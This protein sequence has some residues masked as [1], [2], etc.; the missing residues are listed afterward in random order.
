MTGVILGWVILSFALIRMIISLVN[1]LSPVFLPRTFHH[2]ERFVSVL[3]PA[4]N[5][6]QNLPKLLSTLMTQDHSNMEVLVYDDHSEDGTG[7]VVRKFSEKDNRIQLIHG[8]ELPHGWLGKNFACHQLATHAR[9]AYL[10]FLDADVHV[11]SSLVNRCVQYVHAHQLALLSFFPRQEIRS[12]GEWVT[13]PLMNWILLTLL[14]LV[15]VRKSPRPSLAAANGQLMMFQTDIYHKHQWHELV[16]DDL[17]E[18]IV[19]SREMKEKGYKVC[20]LLGSDDVSCRMYTSFREGVNG[21]AKNVVEFFGGNPY[22]AILFALFILSGIVIV[23][24]FLG[25]IP[26]LIYL[27]SI[28]LTKVFV[29]LLSRQSVFNN[30]LFHIPQMTSFIVMLYKGILVRFSGAYYWKGRKIGGDND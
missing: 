23:P 27:M 10:L 12:I 20:T 16:K 25:T 5:E 28:I 11:S 6:A 18:D 29:S 17:V 22:V 14:P 19:I 2:S 13:V 26:F 7:D 9:G 30:L 8:K 21:F 24:I 3:I 1:L 15:L 4:R